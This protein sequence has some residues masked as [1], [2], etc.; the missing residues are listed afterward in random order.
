[1]K[2]GT[3]SLPSYNQLIASLRLLMKIYQVC[4]HLSC[5]FSSF[6]SA[7]R[8]KVSNEPLVRWRYDKANRTSVSSST[9]IISKEVQASVIDFAQTILLCAQH[10]KRIVDDTL[11][12]SKLESNLLLIAPDRIQPVALV[13]RTM[14][15]YDAELCEAGISHSILVQES[16]T[17]LNID[18]V[19][20]DT[21]R[22]LQVSFVFAR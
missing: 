21:A 10:Q 4:F 22:L 6:E 19:L 14:Q 1:M 18:Y 5:F 13:E 17:N 11:T 20:L 8:R 3:L 7:A 16:Y 2:C 15:M 9:Q 12:L